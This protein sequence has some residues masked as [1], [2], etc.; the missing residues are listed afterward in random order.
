MYQIPGSGVR[1]GGLEVGAQQAPR[2][3]VINIAINANIQMKKKRKYG[4]AIPINCIAVVGHV[5]N[6]LQLFI[7]KQCQFYLRFPSLKR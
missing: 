6:A 2:L 5:V 3:L 7:Q 1:A 4:K